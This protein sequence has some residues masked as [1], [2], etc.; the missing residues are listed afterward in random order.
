[1]AQIGWAAIRCLIWWS[2]EGAPGALPRNSPKP[3]APALRLTRTQLQATAKA[4]LAPFDRGASGE[5][6]Y[7][8]QYDLQETMQDLVGIVRVE[9]EMQQ[10]LEAIAAIA[11]R[12]RSGRGSPAIAST[13]TAG[14]RR[15]I[16]A[17]C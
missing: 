15:S 2:S 5:N 16:S 3:T 6:P 8:I 11:R 7:Q 1:M 13:T 17:T 4:A 9:A 10:A 14:T 12:G